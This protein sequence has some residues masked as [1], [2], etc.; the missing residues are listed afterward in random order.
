MGD[1]WRVNAFALEG[2][3]ISVDL[4]QWRRYNKENRALMREKSLDLRFPYQN[5][6]LKIRSLPLVF[7]VGLALLL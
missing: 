5:V 2:N 3:H 7:G 4:W 1:I 6:L